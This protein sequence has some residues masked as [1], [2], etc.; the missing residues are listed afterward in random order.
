[1]LESPGVGRVDTP[2]TKYAKSGDINI[3]YQVIGDGPIDI[4]YAPAFV[5]HAD[6]EWEEPDYAHWMRRLSRFSRLILFDK[7]G[8]GLSDRDVA[9]ST[10]EERVEDLRAV[11]DAVGS[12]QCT[13]IGN[14]EGGALAILFTA[15]FPER[16][17]RLILFAATYCLVEDPALPS[18][19]E[20]RQ[21]YL[22]FI[23]YNRLHWGEGH[24]LHQH[25]PS[26]RLTAEM[27]ERAGKWERAA[28][29]PRTA[30]NYLQWQLEMDVRPVAKNLR[31]PTLIMH[32]TGDRIVPVGS[33]RWLAENI[34]GAR[35]LELPGDFHWPWFDPSSTVSRAIE[36]FVT[37]APRVPDD[38]QPAL[39]TNGGSA[40]PADAIAELERYREIL[41]AGDDAEVVAGIVAR[42]HAIAA[43]ARGAWSEAEAQFLKAAE[44]FRRHGMVWQ[45]AHTFQ[46]WGH[47]LQAGPDRRAAV[48]KLET[49][50]EMLRG[51]QRTVDTGS[52]RN[53]SADAAARSSRRAAFRREGDY[54]TISSGGSVMRLKDAKGLHYIAYLLGRPG[55]EVFAG[56]LATV[57]TTTDVQPAPPVDGN[58]RPDLGDAGPVLDVRAREQYRRRLADLEAELE[59]AARLNDTG[60]V[61]RLR[62][63]FEAVCE[64]V[65]AAVGFGARDRRTAS[66]AERARLMVTKAIKTA[67]AKIR[68]NHQALGRHLA[69]SIT[70]GT[71]CVYDPGPEAGIAWDL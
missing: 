41:A 2:K 8:T 9:D 10:L 24:L 63:E 18:A 37:G 4:I 62:A 30:I 67:L 31:T 34:P 50:I 29:T 58:V 3:A 27:V 7:R 49:A 45:E 42:A 19:L 14:C 11:L 17:S 70:T 60:R 16:V 48:E 61:E 65:A 52:R 1:M 51:R 33:S 36:E 39:V 22:R 59:G 47:A 53:G 28:A 26:K 55:I 40:A 15:T 71:C 68:A 38:A 69:T 56:V 13:I 23:E 12:R 32:C 44:T 66:H 6:L 46:S 20:Q 54:W 35:Y 5:S 25:A 64:Q 21:K 43:A 57:A